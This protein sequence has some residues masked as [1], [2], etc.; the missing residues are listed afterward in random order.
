MTPRA[1]AEHDGRL[2]VIFDDPIPLIVEVRDDVS[3]PDAL[4]PLVTSVVVDADAD[5]PMRE[6]AAAIAAQLGVADPVR[7][8]ILRV[9]GSLDLD[10]ALGAIDLRNG[11]TLVFDGPDLPPSR[12][13]S[14]QLDLVVITGVL[15][16]TRL[17]LTLGRHMIGRDPIALFQ[18]VDAA[19]SR[20]HCLLDVAADGIT[21]HDAGSANGTFVDGRRVHEATLVLPGELIE[22]G[23]TRFT[24]ILVPTA[25]EAASASPIGGRVPFNRSPR[26]TR[27]RQPA[28]VAMPTPPAIP[29]KGRLPLISCLA[30]LVMA[31]VI[32]L[33]T[34]ILM[35]AL[36]MIMSPV[37]AAFTYVDDRR[38][39]GRT[40]TKDVASFE[41]DLGV[42]AA[43][44]ATAHHAEILARRVEAP[45]PAEL[46]ARVDALALDL[47]ER[48]P[49][50]A[51]FLALRAGTGDLPSELI[52]DAEDPRGEIEERFRDGIERIAAAH[53]IDPF[54]PVVVPLGV[55]GVIGIAGG[56][57]S[58]RSL[59]RALVVD[60]VT[61]QSPRD[62]A[63][64][65]LV[66]PEEVSEWDWLRWLPHTE[67]FV[68][69]VA[70]ARA[71]A[72]EPEEARVLLQMLES[73]LEA[74][75]GDA[76]RHARDAGEY[77]PQVLVVIPGAV[78]VSQA[79]L[80]KV[81]HD[82]PAFGIRA[83]VLSERRERL[84]GECRVVADLDT[85]ASDGTLT[86]TTTGETYDPV[87]FDAV[88]VEA[89]LAVAHRLA[90][91]RDITA[92]GAT[93]D[94]AT[95]VSLLD[96]LGLAEP[97]AAGVVARWQRG[98]P[99]LGAPVA[100]AATGSF[101]I[102]LRR[103]GPHALVAGT[104]G[105]GKSELL[106]SLVVSL[107]AS[108][109]P[110]RLAF[111]L[112][113]YKGGAAFTHCTALPHTVGFF[114]DLDPHLARRALVSLEAELRH[115]EEVL[116]EGGARDL[117]DLEARNPALAPP[118]LVIVIDEFAF[119]K[120]EVPEFVDGLVDIA[121]R[122]RS[123]GVH[124]VLATQRPTGVIDD[125][126]RAN[127]NLRI[128]LRVADD[129]ESTS[130]IGRPDAARIPKTFAGRAFVRTG[131]T[132]I[133]QVQTAY[134]GGP[135]RG[136]AIGEVRVVPFRFGLG[137]HVSVERA[138]D[139]PDAVT[140]LQVLVA[141]IAAAAREL[142]VAE[143]RPPWL[144]P[145]QTCYPLASLPGATEGLSAT[146]GMVDE[147]AAQRQRP[148]TLNLAG[149]GHLLV[150]GTA[151]SGKTT[152]LRTLA[153]ALTA[154]RSTSDVQI[155]AVDAASRALRSLEAL[156]HCGAVV[157]VD[158]IER[159]EQLANLI[160]S[161]MTERRE[162]LGAVGA[163]S[164]AEYRDRT[165]EAVPYLVLML[166]SWS[167]F[168]A[169]FEDVDHG[170]MLDRFQQ[171]V[172]DGRALG[173]HVV[174][175]SER[176]SG[177]PSA[178]TGAI[179]ARLVLRLADDDEYA[180]LGVPAAKGAVLPAGRAFVDGGDEVQLAIVGDQPS[181][182]AQTD[183]VI[184]LG[185]RLSKMDVGEP[186]PPV[187]T[188]PAEV[189]RSEL[190]P[191]DGALTA[192]LGLDAGLR[193]AVVELNEPPLFLVAGPAG[194]GRST[195]LIA[196]ASALIPNVEAY[197]LRPRTSPLEHLSGWNEVATTREACAA[198]AA[199]LA[200]IVSERSASG[201]DSPLL[202][203]IDDGDEMAE[204]AVAT[205]LETLVRVGRDVGVMLVI[206]AQNF[207]LH[208]QYSGWLRLARESRS[209]LL[210][211][212]DP[213]VDGELFATRLP[214]KTSHVFPPGR[215][216]LVRRGTVTLVQVAT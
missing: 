107:A 102:D 171:I 108:H 104:T 3:R 97:D 58:A 41:I 126:I 200:Q 8:A 67:H 31:G 103:D 64:I 137:S 82:G 183:A 76:A 89:A 192:V 150:Y 155:Y 85:D 72:S 180:W 20:R 44:A 156:P 101:G 75:K 79:T 90:G 169:T 9:G 128:A 59:L 35:F 177:V 174:I 148:W 13:V 113:D 100:M 181:G 158:E 4:V 66:P 22:V 122:G 23:D 134:I 37:M 71:V 32:V 54:V 168:R 165:G 69:P 78:P 131:H 210:L 184:E 42:A 47:W 52:L 201:E 40:Y 139:A 125:N 216:F 193:P 206:G 65:A 61:H 62:L 164:L 99:G 119:L 198:L 132:E 53:A 130:V 209:G 145:L 179:P 36:F 74:R 159:V 195:A 124:L 95:Q 110:E 88:T 203:V 167:S 24:V 15:A 215:G 7:L 146:L 186:A 27:P 81:L 173:V 197:L 50:D 93:G 87:H 6:L 140:D 208:R 142:S 91:V 98:L 166:D 96:Q 1:Q 80:S 160:E 92:R 213:D 196:V 30:P 38:R 86:I 2:V 94:L 57:D 21:V 118:N 51:D 68:A 56:H 191:A 11:D 151:G 163:G 121:Q 60:A 199:R 77:L 185:A 162:L 10:V 45:I 109:R 63:V 5:T 127:T 84:P 136:A 17:P 115:R 143:L 114:T 43:E 33:I 153:C 117:I 190:L 188:L 154:G 129:E 120:R 19:V 152:V 25:S 133:E 106:Q 205:A 12:Q 83:L 49:G 29:R 18:P 14:A 48:R 46:V 55:H 73:F 172:T 28:K 189:L 194:S 182:D 105:A 187:R 178:L 161:A 135:H 176:R 70:G 138:P 149:E 204:G 141:A 175:T 16:G 207:A 39:G 214:R 157:P 26:V 34:K 202:V 212:P 170:T 111:V 116:R 147:P 144:D 112:I 211:M 123:L